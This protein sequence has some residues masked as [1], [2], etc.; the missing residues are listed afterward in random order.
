MRTGTGQP[1]RSRCRTPA[2]SRCQVWITAGPASLLTRSCPRCSLFWQPCSL[3]EPT[4]GI[5]GF[6]LIS[7]SVA[8]SLLR[9]PH[10]VVPT[11]TLHSCRNVPRSQGQ[12]PGVCAG[13]LEASDHRS[14]GCLHSMSIDY[15]C[16]ETI[17][18]VQA[19]GSL[20]VTT[21]SRQSRDI[22]QVRPRA[23]VWYNG[24]TR[25]RVGTQV[26]F[27]CFGHGFM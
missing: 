22:C 1:R 10:I 7:A 13:A 6:T 9:L 16:P 27:G 25:V 12:L 23:Q 20:P 21:M 4:P 19:G 15:P 2:L 24:A 8:D 18:Q 26:F 5:P 17:T 11:S 3:E 14:D